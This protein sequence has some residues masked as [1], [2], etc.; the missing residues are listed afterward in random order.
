MQSKLPLVTLLFFFVGKYLR[1]IKE[2]ER[3]K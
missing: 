1:V 3:R 2:K